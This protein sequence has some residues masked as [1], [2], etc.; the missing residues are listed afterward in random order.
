ARW[1]AAGGKALTLL[2]MGDVYMTLFLPEA[3]AGKIAM[4]AEAH[5]VLD[6]MPDRPVPA[7]VTFVSPQAQFT[8]KQVET[9]RERQK[10]VFRVKAQVDAAFLAAHADLA[11]PGLP[12]MG[13]VRLEP[14]APWPAPAR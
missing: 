5:I 9:F 6:A 11:K 3:E 4:N 1:L 12:G 13:Y 10:L 2:D 8:P 14:S 7:R